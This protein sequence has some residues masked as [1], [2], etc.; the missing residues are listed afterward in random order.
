M[1]LC[2]PGQTVLGPSLRIFIAGGITCTP[3]QEEQ[4]PSHQHSGFQIYS[5]TFFCFRGSVFLL[6]FLICFHTWYN[7]GGFL[8]GITSE[9]IQCVN[10]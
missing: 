4:N 5:F 8:P 6:P 3:I 1:E 7:L 9:G 10:I 2:G